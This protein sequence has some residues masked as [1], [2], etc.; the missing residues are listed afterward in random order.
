VERMRA[1]KVNEMNHRHDWITHYSWH[2]KGTD[3]YYNV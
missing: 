3:I 1:T 2:F